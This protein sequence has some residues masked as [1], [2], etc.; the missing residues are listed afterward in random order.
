MET[1]E[2][3]AAGLGAGF[4]LPKQGIHTLNNLQK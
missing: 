3:L 4:G 1:S 2:N